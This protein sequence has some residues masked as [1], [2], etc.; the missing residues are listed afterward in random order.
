MAR[1]SFLKGK[2]H[3]NYKHGLSDTPIHNVWMDMIRRCYKPYRKDYKRYG[4]R[5]IKVCKR[6]LKSFS[7]FYKDMGDKPKGHT[8]DR[9]DNNANYSKENCKWSTIKQQNRNQRQS[10]YI[11]YNKKTKHLKEWSEILNINYNTLWARLFRFKW[12]VSDAFK[13]K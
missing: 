5:G 10:I 13:N 9:I 2:N 8:L 12:S 3:L 4:G 7:N 11:R 6:W 1:H